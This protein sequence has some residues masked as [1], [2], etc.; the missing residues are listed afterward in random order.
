[1]SLQGAI[2]R[3]LDFFKTE[4][5]KKIQKWSQRIINLVV[6]SWLVYQLSNIGW[7]DVWQ[8]L[9]TQPLFYVL[10]LILFIQLPLF[11]IFIYRLTWY[12]N[13]LQ[14]IP[15]FF[16]KRVFNKDIMGYSGEVYFFTWATKILG[17]KKTEAFQIIKDNNII[18]SVAST[19]M[20]IGLLSIFFFT[21]QIKIIDWIANQNLMYVVGGIIAV[22]ALLIFFIKFRHLVI[23][24]PSKTALQIFGLQMG[25]LLLVQTLNLFMYYVV[26]PTVPLYIWFTYIAIEIILS[27]IPFLPSKD[28]IFVGIGISIAGSLPVS[29][30]AIAGIVVARSVLGKIGGFASFG[31]AKMFKQREVVPDPKNSSAVFS[32][33]DKIEE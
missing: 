29:Q 26:L 18:S 33:L 3:L 16:I 31:I 17:I 9:P 24:M 15:I 5:G 23:S 7:L 25:R 14:S 6:L 21:N 19:L 4:R 2:N 22:I 12:F 32:Q 28:L 20:S 27:R 1:M 10:F 8:A 11:E 13:A 30:E